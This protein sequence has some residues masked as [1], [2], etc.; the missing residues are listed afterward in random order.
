MVDDRLQ[1]RAPCLDEMLMP[2][3]ESTGRKEDACDSAKK[4]RVLIVDDSM[5][6]RRFLTRVLAE[7]AAFEV[8]GTASNGALALLREAELQ[9]DVITMDIEMPGMD[10]LATVSALRARGSKSV[11]VMCSTLTKHG[12]QSTIEALLRG[13]ND[14]VTKPAGNDSME[15]ALE[16]MRL[17]LI[18]KIRQFFGRPDAPRT[19]FRTG[20]GLPSML[21]PLSHPD[22]E[23]HREAAHRAVPGNPAEASSLRAE[24]VAIGVSTGGPT[25]LLNLLPRLPANFPL[26]IVIVQH[27]PPIFTKQLA[28]RLNTECAIQVS[29]AEE[30]MALEA[31]RAFV[32][33]GG[34]HMRLKRL[35]HA[36]QITLD[37]GERENSCR[38]AV[39]AL[40][41]SVAAIY[42]DRTLSVI[43]TGMGQDGL[44]GAESLKKKGGYVIAQDRAS[45]VVWGMPGAVV[46]AGLANAV[47]NL[48][49]I[50][51]A[52]LR[53][54]AKL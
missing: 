5:V 31:G 37:D 54:V 2:S 10:G 4:I 30:G 9:P 32:A 19:R 20:S 28:E 45:S 48:D 21:A 41:R 8:V 24:I 1:I 44:R 52:I 15:S 6:I 50:A 3:I 36:V 7:D 18:P 40:F 51:T 16:N 11:I 43:L 13:A 29:E 23:I 53:L 12:G 25:A 47:I 38:P 34:R 46:E 35:L 42:G 27:M 39:D 26:P 14:Y 22:V 49:E 17:E 33:P